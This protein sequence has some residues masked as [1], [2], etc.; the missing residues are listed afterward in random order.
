MIYKCIKNL[1]DLTPLTLLLE[2][3]AYAMPITYAYAITGDTYTCKIIRKFLYF[4][5]H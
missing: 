1:N 4:Y 3:Y 2:T 5:Y